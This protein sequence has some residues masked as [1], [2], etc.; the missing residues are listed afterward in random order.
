MTRISVGDASL[1]NLLARQGAQLRAGVQQAATE[2]A[3]GRPTDVGQALRG[4]FSPLLAVDASLARL[5]AY[6]RNTAEAALHT[7]TQQSVIGG[8]S[9]MAV[10]L[11]TSILRSKD[12]AT[13]AQVGIFAADARGRLASAVG[14]LNAQPA[15]R[16]VFSGV[17]TDTQPLGGAEALLDALQ[18]AVGAATTAGEVATRVATWY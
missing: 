3:T 2:V 13:P 6:G 1:T 15:G 11:G 14:L 10:D 7:A 4:D 12:L 5:K 8:L 9:G 16:A 18:T 17:A